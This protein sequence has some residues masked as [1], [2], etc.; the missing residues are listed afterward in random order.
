MKIDLLCRGICALRPGI[1][2]VS[3]NI[4]VV[5]IVDRFLEHSRIFYFG[6][7][8]EPEVYIGSADWMDRN[9]S[10]RVEV[11]F[12]IEPIALKNRVIQE[13]LLTSLQDNVKARELLPDG[14]Y[15]RVQPKEGEAPFRSQEKFLELSRENATKRGNLFDHAVVSTIPGQSVSRRTRRGKSSS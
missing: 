12:P 2:G 7:D 5:S 15:R 14:S 3:E 4:R 8:G 9:L 11:V 6:S 10:R 1:P 13:V